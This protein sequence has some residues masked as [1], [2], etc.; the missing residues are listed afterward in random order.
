M[1]S[2]APA[3]ANVANGAPLP[4]HFGQTVVVGGG[5]IVVGIP[6]FNETSANTIVRAD[7]GS[8]RTYST[9]GTIPSAGNSTTDSSITS[10]KV[11][12]PAEIISRGT[13]SS[14][15]AS[16]TYYD[17]ATRMLFVGSPGENKL[18][19]Y[20]NEG[21]HWRP[22]Q[23]LSGGSG[24]GSDFDMDGQW[25]VVGAPGQDKVYTFQRGSETWSS[26]KTPLSGGGGFGSSVAIAGNRLVVGA[27]TTTVNYSSANQPSVGYQT[28][29]GHHGCRLRLH[30]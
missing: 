4:D 9:T 6:G 3:G 16:R 8:I 12:P 23:T 5:R 28:A 2:A 15:F 21:L 22:T 11:A 30:A 26:W 17:S 1:E 13:S 14:N 27:P 29:A 20:I 25:L 10:G 7:V 24:F 18:Y 19:I